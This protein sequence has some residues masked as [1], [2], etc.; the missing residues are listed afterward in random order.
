MGIKV[1]KW[2]RGLLTTTFLAQMTVILVSSNRLQSKAGQG[3]GQGHG[4]EKKETFTPSGIEQG[5]VV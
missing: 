5:E 3:Q 4:K 2:Y 1:E